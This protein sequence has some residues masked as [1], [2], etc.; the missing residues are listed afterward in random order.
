[1][2]KIVG[3]GPESTM[4]D[5]QQAFRRDGFVLIHQLIDIGD[6][7]AARSSI[8]RT[9]ADAGLL[10][11]D[12][13]TVKLPF[14]ES[15][16]AYREAVRTPA[17]NRLAYLPVLR[18]L[19]QGLLDDTAFPL[20]TKLLRA[21]PPADMRTPSGRYIHQDYAFWGVNDMVTTWLPLME[22]PDNLGGLALKRG[23]HLGPPL[24]L[25]QLTGAD[26]EWVTANYQ[27]GDVLAFHCLTAH[28]SLPNRRQSVR[29]SGDFRWLQAHTSLPRELVFG[30]GASR[31]EALGDELRRFEW[32][33]PVPAGLTFV[34]G[35]VRRVPTSAIFPVSSGWRQW[36]L[37]DG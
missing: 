24:E 11:S 8:V 12:D 18:E 3:L 4:H 23:S 27:P 20:P 1:M 14:D 13:L 21:I 9:L 7:D 34:D 36:A 29:L 5:I 32:W 28:A 16:E 37:Q 17:F 30:S 33:L 22:I 31:S 26:E 10:N 25:R 6:I 15:Y 2:D 19:V 35:E